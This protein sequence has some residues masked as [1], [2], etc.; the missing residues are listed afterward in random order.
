MNGVQL[1]LIGLAGGLPDIL[2]PHFSLYQRMHSWTHTIWFL[3]GLM[4][5]VLL[6]AKWKI[7]EGYVK[8]SILFWLAAMS[9][10]LL[11]GLSGGINLFFPIIKRIGTYY[12]S[13]H[14]WVYYDI[15]FVCLM[16][17]VLIQR[18][19]VTGRVLAS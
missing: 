16:I 9:H 8:F 11:D 6:L 12:I 14:T 10:I 17:V 15:T 18:K 3:I 2:W 7:R 19:I 13:Y 5:V 1:F 4:P